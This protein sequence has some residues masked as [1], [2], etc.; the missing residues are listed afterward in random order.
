M[1][2]T[3]SCCSV[4]INAKHV[5]RATEGDVVAN[6]PATKQFEVFEIDIIANEPSIKRQYKVFETNL[7]FSKFNSF[8]SRSVISGRIRPM[9]RKKSQKFALLPI[10]SKFGGQEVDGFSQSPSDFG[11]RHFNVSYMTNF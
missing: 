3:T 1:R 6:D 11:L 4:A 5:S 10:P 2:P 9:K 7:E 8:L